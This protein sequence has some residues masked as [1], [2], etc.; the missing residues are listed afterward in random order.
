MALLLYHI[1]V[2]FVLLKEI[3]LYS[4]LCSCCIRIVSL[5]EEDDRRV[6]KIA[7]YY[8]CVPLVFLLE[9]DPP[10]YLRPSLSLHVIILPLARLF[11]AVHC[12]ANAMR[13]QCKCNAHATQCVRMQC[14][15]KETQLEE[16]GRRNPYR[17]WL[18]RHR[19]PIAFPVERRRKGGWKECPM[20]SYYIPIAFLMYPFCIALFFWMK[21]SAKGKV[22]EIALHSC[23]SCVVF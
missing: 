2:A 22:K 3:A 11:I 7:L 10:P 18:Y 6:E 19:I 5:L 21:S 15:A 23:C 1:C 13:M 20:R 12:A 16:G 9:E 14:N 4:L 17:C 8:Y